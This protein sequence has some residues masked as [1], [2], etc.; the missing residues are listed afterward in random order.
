MKK[1][2]KKGLF[3]E[4]YFKNNL[5]DSFEIIKHP[6]EFSDKFNPEN[7]RPDFLI[8]HKKSKVLTW[9]ECKYQK[10]DNSKERRGAYIHDLNYN[11]LK[12]YENLYSKGNATIYLI[13][14]FRKEFEVDEMYLVHQEQTKIMNWETELKKRVF[15]SMNEFENKWIRESFE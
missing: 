14:M 13:G 10:L 1:S 9:I 4:D 5:P 11:Q 3:F 6:P 2:F 12:R 8:Q 15:F 7:L